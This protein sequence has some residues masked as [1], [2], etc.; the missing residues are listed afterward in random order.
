MIRT[1][2]IAWLVC[3]NFVS[4]P[5]VVAAPHT[6]LVQL[7]CSMAKRLYDQAHE[8]TCL[9]EFERALGV[10]QQVRSSVPRQCRLESDEVMGRYEANI[11]T[12]I[13]QQRAGGPPTPCRPIQTGPTSYSCWTSYELRD[14]E[15]EMCHEIM[16]R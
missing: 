12:L 4:I 16:Q 9:Q 1:S 8:A 10:L 7:N 15:K 5:P 11:R 13:A 14:K 2:T 6:V 3:A